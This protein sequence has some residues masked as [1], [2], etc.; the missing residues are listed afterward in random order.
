MAIQDEINSFTSSCGASELLRLSA[1]TNKCTTNRIASVATV[2]DLPDLTNGTIDPGTV[3]YVDSIKVPAI[4]HVGCWAGLDNRELRNDFNVCRVYAWG[5]SSCG[6]LG[7]NTTATWDIYSPVITVGAI[8]D[9]CQISAGG[10]HSL[11]LRA[12]GTLWAWGNGGVLGDDTNVKRSSPVLVAGG[13]TDWCQID[14]GGYHSLAIR[15]NGTLWAWGRGL[16]GQL[17]DNTTVAKSS[18]VSVVG[19]FT[20]WCQVSAKYHSAG[21]RTNG[22]LWAW[23]YNCLGEI[24]DNTTISKSSPVSVVGGFTDWCQVSVGSCNTLAIRTDGTLWAW[25]SNQFGQIGDN[26]TVDKSS[27]V[28]V[29]GGFTD[30]CQVSNGRRNSAAIRTNGSLW[31]WG[32]NVY[33][34]QLGDNTTVNK[35]SPVSVVGGFTDWCRV[36]VG[37][38]HT[39]GLR[40]NGTLWAWG[41]GGF[42]QLGN[43]SWADNNRS[44][45]VS[46]VGGLT[47]CQASAGTLHSLGINIC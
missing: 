12:N 17:G 3:I 42:G 25:G 36:S 16:S 9:W 26:T 35:S 33:Y 40:T 46:V 27:P 41:G 32:Y 28:S 13:F 47:W 22:T 37:N 4:A 39:L 15:T 1:E 14:A 34:A 24:G 10:Q 6:R 19:G 45:P 38:Y 18:P 2:N 43:N 8:T 30:W 7:D 21:I 31:A 29:V 20:D 23:G 11:A 44:S 5:E